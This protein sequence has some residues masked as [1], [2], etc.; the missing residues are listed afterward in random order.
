MNEINFGNV[1]SRI[2]REF[3]KRVALTDIARRTGL[4][5]VTLSRIKTGRTKHVRSATICKIIA[6][7]PFVT[8]EDFEVPKA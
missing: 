3:G 5:I 2:D 1:L 7:Y 8:F 6:A 4:S